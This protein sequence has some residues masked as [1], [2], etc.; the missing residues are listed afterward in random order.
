MKKNIALVNFYNKPNKYSF[1]ALVGAVEVDDYF[2]DLKIYF[3]K[4]EN[5]LVEQMSEILKAHSTVIL[6]I[7]FFSTQLWEISNLLT[8]LKEKNR[9]AVLYVA[10]GPHPTGDPQGALKMGFNV[11]VVGEGEEAFPN[12]I[13]AVDSDADWAG[14]KGIAYLDEKGEFHFTGR[15]SLIDLDNFPPFAVAN[16]KFGPIE[17]SRGCPYVCYFCQT[18][19]LFG[20]R[21]RHRSITKICEYVSIM[22]SRGLKDIRFITPNSFS[23]GSRDG[24]ELNIEALEHLLKSVREII[25][26]AGRIFI[27]SFPSEVRPEHVNE[28]TISLI[29][30]YA[31]NKN[32]VIGGQSGSQRILDACH[33][34]HSVEEIYRAVQLTL[35]SGLDANVDFIFGLP[36]EKREDRRETI[37]VMLDLVKMGA[38]IHTHSFMPLPQTPFAKAS[39]GV[40][41]ENLRSIVNE[42]VSKD[43]AYGNWIEQERIAKKIT[44]YLKAGNL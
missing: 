7:S 37:K 29:H 32:L 20:V 34:G 26:E 33:R 42:L 8:E 17:I 21:P 14:V 25:Q 19:K 28:T 1:N 41:D 36:G 5:E 22:K 30:K 39:P 43:K 3:F 11:V 9:N 24:K 27:G 13:K 44:G 38:K 35:K 12:F 2:R 18:P 23:Y 10:G 4:T 6:G 40:I 16:N 15:G 31:N